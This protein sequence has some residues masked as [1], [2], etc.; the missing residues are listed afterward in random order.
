MIFSKQAITYGL[1]LASS[2]LIFQPT[3]AEAS[4]DD[5]PYIGTICWTAAP[6]CP[7]GYLT[8]NGWPYSINDYTSLYSIIGNTFGEYGHNTFRVP[9]L[10]G[11]SVTSPGATS[12]KM[13]KISYGQL[14]GAKETTIQPNQLPSHR[15][16]IPATKPFTVKGHIVGSN[17]IGNTVD[18]YDTY[19]AARPSSGELKE[20]VPYY[21]SGPEHR[22]PMAKT[23]VKWETGISSGTTGPVIDGTDSTEAIPLTPP[24]IAIIA[25]IAHSGL[26]PTRN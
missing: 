11:V 12:T 1:A 23:N 18:P 5:T 14:T 9:N 8:A 15:H 19:P 4:C 3:I 21:S 20:I 13:A 22:V 2:F 25:C 26:Y 7:Y 10:V 16:A 24:Q 6:S 17:E